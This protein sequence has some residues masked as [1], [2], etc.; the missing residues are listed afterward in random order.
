MP[1]IDTSTG[2]HLTLAVLCEKVLHEADGAISVIRVV[3]QLTQTA[4]GPD[5]PAAMP[6]FLIDNL[7]LVVALKADQARGRF[8]VKVRPE[9]PGGIQLPSMEQA[10]TFQSGPS[11]VNLIMPLVL[12]IA[13]E[14]VYWFDV[15]LTGHEPQ[16]DELLTRVPLE[17]IY[18]PQRPPGGS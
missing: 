18:A 5:A 15:F 11:G 10:V 2:P 4:V 16:E 12:P 13:S 9:A 17:V 1:P 7:T 8:G 6:P 14:G 3:D